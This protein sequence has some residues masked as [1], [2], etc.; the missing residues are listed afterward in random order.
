M[1]VNVLGALVSVLLLAAPTLSLAQTNCPANSRDFGAYAPVQNVA[2]MSIH[3][4]CNPDRHVIFFQAINVS[5]QPKKIDWT[6]YT[7]GAGVPGTFDVAAHAV[8]PAID[9]HAGFCPTSNV[10]ITLDPK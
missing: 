7:T 5:D 6:L 9:T 4:S 2:G 8:T 1:M 3:C 10:Y